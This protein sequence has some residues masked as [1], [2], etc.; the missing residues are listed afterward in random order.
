MGHTYHTRIAA[1]GGEGDMRRLCQAMLRN[2]GYEGD[3][4][5]SLDAL[6]EAVRR[7]AAEEYGPDCGFLYEMITRRAYGDAEEDTCRFTVRRE[8]CG[9]WTALFTYE[10]AT[11]F[12]PEDWLRLHVQCDRL[13]MLALRACDDFDRDKGL[14][15][16]SG[17][18]VH[19][20]WSRME[21]CWLW[22]VTRYGDGD[23]DQAIRLLTRLARLLEDEE[24]EL[25]V[26][27]L[28][29]R[30]GRFLQGLRDR[31]HDAE[32]LREQFAQA[33]QTRDY[34]AL[35][36]LQCLVA[37]SVLWEADRAEHWQECLNRL[38][39]SFPD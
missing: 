5:H 19:E 2:A 20:E 17:G 34:Q 3:I 8:P 33:V 1:V 18:Y 15:A 37:Q 14:L 24:D 9:V 38:A 6:T 27:E 32:E 26:P 35:F 21:E 12:Q 29:A 28:L 22:L 11:P 10:S 31:T 16:F 4:P 30:C 7:H 39:E 25:T 13:P 23:P 36:S